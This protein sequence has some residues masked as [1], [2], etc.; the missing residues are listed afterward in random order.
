MIQAPSTPLVAM[1]PDTLIFS[2]AKF[3]ELKFYGTNYTF[4]PQHDETGSSSDKRLSGTCPHSLHPHYTQYFSFQNKLAS[5][6]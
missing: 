6:E 5:F 4:R 1:S 2:F 3:L